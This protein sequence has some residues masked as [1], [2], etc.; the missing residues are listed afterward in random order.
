MAWWLLSSLAVAAEPPVPLA[1]DVVGV[2]A[3][4]V[5]GTVHTCDGAD[6][7]PTVRWSA[8]PPET[9]SYAL[10]VDDPDAPAGTWVHWVAWNLPGDKLALP[11]GVRPQTP[12]LVQGLNDFKQVGWGGPCPP[13]G[14][15]PHRYYFRL[16]GLDTLVDLPTGATRAQLD[17]AMEGHVVAKGE[18]MARYERGRLPR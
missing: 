8:G 12:G 5:I 3:G 6:R 15:G 1:V 7:S 2:Q 18:W 10:V 13:P 14:H 17:A 9:R 4:G 11:E 16:Y